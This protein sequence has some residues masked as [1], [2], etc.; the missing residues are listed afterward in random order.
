MCPVPTYDAHIN[1]NKYKTKIVLY[2]EMA[3]QRHITFF[4]FIFFPKQLDDILYFIHFFPFVLCSKKT[5]KCHRTKVNTRQLGF[6]AKK[7]KN[8]KTKNKIK[9][10]S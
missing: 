5:L 7:K 8:E 6:L 3:T 1:S 9:K 2:L 10:N 4:F